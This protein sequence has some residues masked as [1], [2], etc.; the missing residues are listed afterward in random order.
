MSSVTEIQQAILSLPEADYLQLRRWF[1]ELDWDKWDR[2]IEA[3]SESGKLD[4][5]ITE[6][7]EAKEKGTFKAL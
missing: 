4:L 5:L 1:N 6:T 3:D 7:F 2:Q